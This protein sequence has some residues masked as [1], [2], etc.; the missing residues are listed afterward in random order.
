MN[1]QTH[2]YLSSTTLVSTALAL[3]ALT[4]APA[5][6]GGVTAGTLIENTAV[7]SY[8]EAGIARNVNSNTVTVR[9]DELLDVTLTSLDPGP[10]TARPGDAVLT[11]EL[12]NQG[13]GPEAFRLLANTAVGGN[14]FD[15]TLRAIAIDSNGNGT[16]DEGVDAILT[17]PETTAVLAPDAALT[18]FVLVTVP[19][20]VTDAQ[21]SNV[22]LSA[23]AVTG[24]GTPGTAFAGAG[25]DGGDAIVGNTGALA[26]ARG[27]LVNA[28]ASVAL[29]K[30]VVLRDPFGGTSAVPGTIATFTIEARVSGT[31]S[32]ANLV[33]R[34]AIPA[35][36]TYAPGTLT[37]DTAPLTDATDGDA[38]T[39]SDADGIAVTIGSVTAGTNRAVTF[40]VTLDQ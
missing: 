31:G 23:E 1:T 27:S 5:L 29:V 38:G 13:N 15:V 28:V 24:S 32:V 33:V 39:A 10:V 14:D 36:T 11:F 2:L 3:A 19:D 16:Y 40:E 6:A 20:G 26:T 18:V 37:L 25:V 30:S 34:D 35:G 4:A 22:D 7:A 9:V 21:T 8:E 17:A 12:T